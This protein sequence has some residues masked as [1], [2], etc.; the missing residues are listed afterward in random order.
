MSVPINKKRM[1]LK[2][3]VIKEF[4]QIWRDPSSMAIA[5]AE[6]QGNGAIAE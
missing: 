3:L 5:F 2:G 4:L 6:N 1:R